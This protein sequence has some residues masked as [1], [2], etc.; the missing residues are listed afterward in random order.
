MH[1]AVFVSILQGL[2]MDSAL[3]VMRISSGRRHLRE[4]SHRRP[5]SVAGTVPSSRA[6]AQVTAGAGGEERAGASTAAQSASRLSRSGSRRSVLSASLPPPSLILTLSLPAPSVPCV[7]R[8]G[9]LRAFTNFSVPP[10]TTNSS[11]TMSECAGSS[12]SFC[13]FPPPYLLHTEMIAPVFPIWT[14]PTRWHW[15]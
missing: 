10:C 3:I 8:R 2:K 4:C 7:S 14:P 12:A 9:V 13:F 5:R 15:S 11:W 6:R 1:D